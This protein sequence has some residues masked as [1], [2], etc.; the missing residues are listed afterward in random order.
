MSGKTT[1]Y[2]EGIDWFRAKGA[3]SAGT[4]EGFNNKAKLTMS[5]A[6]GFRIFWAFELALYHTLGDLPQPEGPHGF[7]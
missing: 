4:V 2:G 3:I 7:N 5:R 6:Y 1:D